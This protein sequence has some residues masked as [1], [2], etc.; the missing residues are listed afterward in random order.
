MSLYDEQWQTTLA[1]VQDWFDIIPEPFAHPQKFENLEN[2]IL[3][4][5][6]EYAVSPRPCFPQ[7]LES[8]VDI[9]W[10]LIEAPSSFL[11]KE[12]QSNEGAELIE[13]LRLIV[14]KV[15]QVH[16]AL[17]IGHMTS[18]LPRYV[19]SLMYLLASLNQNT[20]KL[21]TSGGLTLVEKHTL[22][23]VHQQVFGFGDDHYQS[24]FADNGASLGSFC[25][26]GTIGNLTALWALRKGWQQQNSTAFQQLRL[27][28]SELGHYSIRKS[29]DILGFEAHQLVVIDADDMQGNASKLANQLAIDVEQGLQPFVIIGVAGATETGS[30]D[31]LKQ[32][33]FLAKKHACF[34]HVDAAWGGAFCFSKT[35]RPLLRGIEQ[36][37]TVVIDA[38][39][40]LYTPT[41]CGL[42]LFKCAN[43]S[44][45]IRFHAN[46]IIRE[47]SYDLGQF[48][49]EGSRPALS[50]VLFA[51]LQV[52]G[53]AGL[54]VLLESLHKRAQEFASLILD[55]KDFELTSPPTLNI[56]T[57]RY[58]PTALVSSQ[59]EKNTYFLNQINILIQKK[60]RAAGRSFV[61]RTKLKHR[62]ANNQSHELLDVFRV[63]IANPRTTLQHCVNILEEQQKLA[64]NNEIQ[65]LIQQL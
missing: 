39:K 41:G 11:W 58:N 40:Q 46:Y 47:G 32:L 63:V 1:R 5:A 34:F 13:Q 61:S 14:N 50:L 33:A 18:A 53:M 15:V 8:E 16:S 31:N 51:H 3:G 25:S 6:Q 9:F 49:L 10:S 26:G 37:D 55:A 24:I 29:I 38:H 44:Q 43:M 17:F 57:Y 12:P 48:T 2:Q 21:E 22:H 35:L 54:G 7:G 45:F 65:A 20:V 4:I 27:Y 60:Q 59:S 28:V 36:A 64:Q 42:V 56:L 30:I 23:L 52:L 62:N 19:P